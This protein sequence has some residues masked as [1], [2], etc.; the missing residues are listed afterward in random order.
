MDVVVTESTVCKC[1]G[2]TLPKSLQKFVPIPDSP[3]MVFERATVSHWVSDG[4]F[5]KRV[6]SYLQIENLTPIWRGHS[7]ALCSAC[8]IERSIWYLFDQ[9]IL[10]LGGTINQINGTATIPFQLSCRPEHPCIRCIG[11]GS[12]PIPIIKPEPEVASLQVTATTPLQVAPLHT[13][14]LAEI[15]SGQLQ[16]HQQIKTLQVAQSVSEPPVTS[17]CK[18]TRATLDKLER[19]LMSPI[20]SMQQN[21]DVMV[22]KEYPIIVIANFWDTEFLNAHGFYACVQLDDPYNLSHGRAIAVKPF[23]H[24]SE[25]QSHM[26][27]GSK[28]KQLYVDAHQALYAAQ[29]RE[30]KRMFEDRADRIVKRMR[31]IKPEIESD[32]DD[33]CIELQYNREQL[34]DSDN[35]YLLSFDRQP[36]TQYLRDHEKLT[37]VFDVDSDDDGDV[38]VKFKNTKVSCSDNVIS[39]VHDTNTQ[40]RIAKMNTQE[41]RKYLADCYGII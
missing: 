11:D 4:P 15:I 12:V 34:F 6:K 26:I 2:K 3:P 19:A 14:S 21:P 32:S 5:R 37:D 7:S 28:L 29:N 17:T 30:A 27:T 39:I 9:D 13:P 25:P 16:K 41:Y 20:V 22:A 8:N 31:T 10:D 36:L 24:K 23:T 33:D 40:N 38:V 1:S 18:Y 35:E